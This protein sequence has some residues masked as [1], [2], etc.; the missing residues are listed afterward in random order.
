MNRAILSSDF[1]CRCKID[2]VCLTR[3]STDCDAFDTDDD[4][5]VSLL[6]VSPVD[7]ALDR[8]S[9]AITTRS[10]WFMFFLFLTD[11]RCYHRSI[12]PTVAGEILGGY[13]FQHRNFLAKL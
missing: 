8:I 6:D 7:L 11:K 3:A 10:S 5:Q 9:V 13:R 1:F 12:K 2:L 4:G